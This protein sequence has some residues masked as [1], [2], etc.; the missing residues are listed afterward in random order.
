MI[1][2]DKC[3]E[4][5]I[6]TFRGSITLSDWAHDVRV[7]T[8]SMNNPFFDAAQ[9]NKKEKQQGGGGVSSSSSMFHHER[10]HETLRIHAGFYEYLCMAN[11]TSGEESKFDQILRKLHDLLKQHPTYK[12]VVA[13]HSLGGAASTLFAFMAAAASA[14][15]QGDNNDNVD[16]S[17]DNK[18]VSERC[19]MWLPTS[20]KV[21]SLF[22][23]STA[24]AATA[25]APQEPPSATQE[26]NHDDDDNQAKDEEEDNRM[27]NEGSFFQICLPTPITVVSFG[28][29][30]VGD[31]AFCRAFRLLEDH[32]ILRH[33][34]VANDDDIVPSIPVSSIP[35]T[36]ERVYLYGHTGIPL[37]QFMPVK[38]FCIL[39]CICK[40]NK[41]N[42]S[43]TGADLFRI[44]HGDRK[45]MKKNL[46]RNSNNGSDW[47]KDVA[48]VAQ[49]FA[50]A[51][52]GLHLRTPIHHLPASYHNRLHRI[53]VY[54]RR[55]SLDQLYQEYLDFNKSSPN[56]NDDDDTKNQDEPSG[57][58]VS[59][60]QVNAK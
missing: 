2:L 42:Q 32:G 48:V 33:L 3:Y 26:D 10:Q 30:A 39:C 23:I 58:V 34:R 27:Q 9:D 53:E 31:G 7:N 41:Q 12:V 47:Q 17:G 54:L 5:I 4:R 19:R 44:C 38:R 45:N 25:A 1:Y 37:I 49:D 16:N 60:Q 52:G 40:M 59:V 13:G 43:D 56:G 22:G 15:T 6:V 21:A 18:D 57:G 11:R 51:V 29:P 50:D 46:D 36:L 8:H 20:T 24:A 28:S 35:T 55:L 14:A